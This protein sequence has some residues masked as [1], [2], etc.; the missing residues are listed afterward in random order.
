MGQKINPHGLRVQVIKNW[1]SR[2]WLDNCLVK[3]SDYLRDVVQEY[4]KKQVQEYRKK[5]IPWADIVS[6]RNLKINLASTRV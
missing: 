2:W 4:H 6:G 3:V 1:D 5:W